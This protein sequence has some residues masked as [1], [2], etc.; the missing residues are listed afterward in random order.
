MPTVCLSTGKRLISVVANAKSIS[1]EMDTPT[2]RTMES[3]VGIPAGGVPYSR[4]MTPFR[5]RRANVCAVRLT[6][7][8]VLPMLP[9]RRQ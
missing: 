4:R 3:T 2:T 7:N 6:T 9:A 8:K 5:R 1:A